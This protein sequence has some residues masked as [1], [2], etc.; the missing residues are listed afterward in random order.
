MYSHITETYYNLD[1]YKDTL[2]ASL[3]RKVLNSFVNFQLE[4]LYWAQMHTLRAAV[5]FSRQ[6]RMDGF[7]QDNKRKHLPE[8]LGSFITAKALQ[9][10]G[11]KQILNGLNDKILSSLLNLCVEKGILLKQVRGKESYYSLE[12]QSPLEID[13]IHFYEANAGSLAYIPEL[14]LRS[15]VRNADIFREKKD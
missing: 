4:S 15:I 12:L 7:L 6:K 1:R 11:I 8:L 9:Y 13:L 14:F 5:E 10:T 2:K 3:G